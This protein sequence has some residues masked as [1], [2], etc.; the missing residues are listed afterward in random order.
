MLHI[1][2]EFCIGRSLDSWLNYL[3]TTVH[4]SNNLIDGM[5]LK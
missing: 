3:I 2:L 1:E 4:N 5:A